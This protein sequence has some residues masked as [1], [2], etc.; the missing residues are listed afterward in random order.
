VWTI[1][2]D[3]P[4]YWGR[5]RYGVYYVP[6]FL[7][8][9]NFVLFFTFPFLM[10]F[11]FYIIKN[12]SHFKNFS[13]PTTNRLATHQFGKRCHGMF[14]WVLKIYSNSF[15][16]R[17][18]CVT[19]MPRVFLNIRIKLRM[20]SCVSWVFSV[21][22]SNTLIQV[23]KIRLTNPFTIQITISELYTMIHGWSQRRYSFPFFV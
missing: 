16:K 7:P 15:T 11:N 1:F 18:I 3:L 13:R 12:K 8:F 22:P 6:Y 14:R 9:C 4:L 17:T 19:R 2:G 21:S 23:T 10:S 20:V 5:G